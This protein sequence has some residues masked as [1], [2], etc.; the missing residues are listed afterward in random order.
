MSPVPSRSRRFA[1]RTKTSVPS[2][3]WGLSPRP[4]CWTIPRAEWLE[5]EEDGELDDEAEEAGSELE[6]PGAHA[7]D[8]E[9]FRARR[10]CLL[11]RQSCM[12]VRFSSDGRQLLALRRRLPPVL[13]DAA[14]P[15]PLV[16]FDHAGYLNSCTMKNACFA[17]LRD[18]VRALF[19]V[20]EF[21]VYTKLKLN[22]EYCLSIVIQYFLVYFGRLR[23]F[24]SLHVENPE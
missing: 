21:D 11:Q 10:D 14:A 1:R 3:E 19:P 16:Q 20:W 17:G 4:R 8:V 7:D 12:C 6:L 15:V 13:F 5:C 22:I 23:Q 2:C 24:F 9:L 18:Q